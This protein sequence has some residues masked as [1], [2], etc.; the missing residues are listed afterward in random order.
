MERSVFAPAL[1]AGV[2]FVLLVA[3]A[4]RG[5]ETTALEAA[6]DGPATISGDTVT[7]SGKSRVVGVFEGEPGAGDYDCSSTTVMTGFP[8]VVF[9]GSFSCTV[10]SS[11]AT[12]PA[13][14]SGSYIGTAVVAAYSFTGSFEPGGHVIRCQGAGPP[15]GADTS[16][17]HILQHCHIE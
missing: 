4:A 10:A 14:F 15:S 7:W 6:V 8:S 5:H 3:A 17:I 13:A 1:G 9:T 16:M 11:P 2:G 12:W